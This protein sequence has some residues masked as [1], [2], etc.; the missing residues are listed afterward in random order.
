MKSVGVKEKGK[1]LDSESVRAENPL[2]QSHTTTVTEL[3]VCPLSD[4]RVDLAVTLVTLLSAEG[5]VNANVLTIYA[6][7]STGRLAHSITLIDDDI[8]WLSG[9]EYTSA[10]IGCRFIHP[11]I[12]SLVSQKL[13]L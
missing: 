2:T 9:A 12:S 10:R 1:G 11:N 5:G 7:D 3:S 13:G 4:S 8:P 6:P